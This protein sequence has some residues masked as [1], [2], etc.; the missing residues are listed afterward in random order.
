MNLAYE[1]ATADIGDYNELDHFYKEVRCR[2]AP[3]CLSGFLTQCLCARAQWLKQTVSIGDG[4]DR[5][6][7]PKAAP[8][9]PPPSSPRILIPPLP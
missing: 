6:P 8:D 3:H 2:P 1:A 7:R 5:S 9:P 4:E